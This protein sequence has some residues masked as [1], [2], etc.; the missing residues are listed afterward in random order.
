[1]AHA[2]LANGTNGSHRS[3]CFNNALIIDGTGRPATNGGLV[4]KG[5]RIAQVGAINPEPDAT[6]IDLAGKTLMPGMILSHVHLS[7]NHVNDLPDLD[8]K[9]PAEV[10]T[11][12]A[13]CNAKLML[14]CGFTSGLSAG[15]LH[16]VDIHIRNAINAGQIPGP[17]LLAAGRDIC[18]TG[19]MLDWNKSWLK[20]GM[21]GLGVFVDDPWAVRK[22]VRG[23]IKDGADMIKMYI[24]GEG[25]LMEC[26]Q[27]ELTCTYDEIEAMVEEAHRRN[28]LCS[29]HARSSESCQMAAKAGVD[30][31]DHATFIDDETLDV[32]AEHGSFVAPGL[33]YLVSVLEHGKR[34]GFPWLGTPQDFLD[35]TS[36]D[37]ELEASIGNIRKAYQRGI[38]ILVGSDFGFSW[39]PHGTYGRELTHLVKLVGYKPM[40][41]L[42]AATRLGAEAMRMQD[43]IGTLEVG[44]YADVLVVDGNPLEDISILEDRRTIT[45]VMKGGEFVRRPAAELT[46]A[47]V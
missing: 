33:D 47:Y 10:A 1:M 17:R 12:A 14:E 37:K 6:V 29:V 3:L 8:L 30:I 42:V 9:Q 43:R 41:A 44:K 40:D 35:K 2:A 31:I 26:Q 5:E 18:Q 7:Y 4:V 28:R 15:A 46:P 32:I 27:T 24:T 22:A 16:M 25:L 45:H 34:G 21:D 39:T 11:I 38:K 23:M 19:G 20:L 36:S 13:V